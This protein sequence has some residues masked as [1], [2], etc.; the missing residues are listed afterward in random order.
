MFSDTQV[1]TLARIEK[2]RWISERASL[3]WRYDEH[4]SDLARLHNDLR[5][6]NEL[7]ANE[8]AYDLAGVEAMPAI[9]RDRLGLSL[10]PEIIIG[11]TGHRTHRLHGARD[12][13]ET[14]VSD[15]LD[16]IAAEYP[17]ARF[18]VMSALAEGSDR[19][20]AEL[21]MSR[22]GAR[23]YAPLP[24]PY[25][26]YTN[27]FGY[28]DPIKHDESVAEFQRL[29]GRARRYFEMPLKFGA[30][31]MLERDDA[32]GVEARTRQYALV[33]AYLVQRCHEL[34]AV[35]DGDAERGE[36]GTGQIV[37]WRAEGR[38]PDAYAFTNRFFPE[39]PMRS[40]YIVGIERD[41]PFKAHRLKDPVRERDGA[42]RIS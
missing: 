1:Q 39:P 33:G 36:G 28:G 14:R 6:W 19:I 38:V 5:P 20:V 35:W 32:A 8:R 24:L 15:T 7:N 31:Q 42:R 16:A 3:G 25:E 41:E 13:I 29:V 10:H 27:Q 4:R 12:V 26:I 11:V 34:I 9:L 17:G 18:G 2:T 40:P 21:A 22:L 23:L 37:R 30:A